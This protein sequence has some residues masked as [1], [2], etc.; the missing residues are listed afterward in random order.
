MLRLSQQ[1]GQ[2]QFFAVLAPAN[3]VHMDA[4]LSGKKAVPRPQRDT[5]FSVDR[6]GEENRS[7]ISIP[8]RSFA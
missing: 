2:L 7:G 6:D 5:T 4:E 8:A 1:Y 3:I